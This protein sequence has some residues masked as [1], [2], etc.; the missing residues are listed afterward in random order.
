[1]ST[2]SVE[3]PTSKRSYIS[4]T[5]FNGLIYSYTT[6]LNS[7]NFKN[8]GRLLPLTVLPS[9]GALTS[10]NCPAGRILRE[11]G[12]KLFPGVN[13]GLAIGDKYNGVVV[14]NS[15]TD[16]LWVM[17]FDQ[18]SGLRGFIDPNAPTF[19]VY[20]T[21]RTADFVDNA[22]NAAGL[23]TRLGQP[24]N[25]AGVVR[26]NQLIASGGT[27]RI[28]MNANTTYNFL[29]NPSTFYE[30]ENLTSSNPTLGVSANSHLPSG[31]IIYVFFKGFNV[32]LSTGFIYDQSGPNVNANNANGILMSFVSNG[33]LFIEISRTSL[34][35]SP[36]TPPVA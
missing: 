11:V 10:T 30:V 12:R 2:L 8:E 5:P 27:V 31:S 35:S 16:H 6:Q 13:P 7:S 26:A 1:M 29:A 19:A 14:G 33:S 25:T 32:V 34:F 20:S 24:V 17:V 36:P 4:A 23:P 18:I 15:S 9:G 22:E 21:D 28:T 3:L